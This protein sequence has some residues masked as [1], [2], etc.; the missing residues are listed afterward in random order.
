MKPDY[1][2]WVPKGMI[3]AFTAASLLAL[4]LLLVVLFVPLGLPLWLYIILALLLAITTTICGWMSYWSRIAA[5]AFDYNGSLQLAR[6][7]VEGTAAA[8]D[9]PNGGRLLDV[10]CGSGALGIACLKQ[11]P[12][13]TLLG[14]DRWGQEY[15]SF[16]QALCERNA[17]AE[18]VAD[19]AGFQPGNATKLEF[20]D[21]TFDAVVS[22]YVYHNIPGIKKQQLLLE[23]LR[24]LRKG[25]AFAIHDLM[26]PARYGDMEAFCEQLRAMGYSRV[27]LL[28]T[29]DGLFLSAAEARR[30]LLRGSKLLVGIK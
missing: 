25:G 14:V 26:S 12:K 1:K 11:N 18:G 17:A 6:R 10:G 3:Y 5:K 27:E 8:L 4:A 24:T 29:D 28:P 30:Y 9:C 7:I 21:E 13:L 15:A 23:T 16:S 22:N 2:N 20:P 19:R